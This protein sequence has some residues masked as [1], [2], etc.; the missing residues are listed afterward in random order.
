MCR[1]C[2][3][4]ELF[5]TY[6]FTVDQRYQD[7][8]QMQIMKTETEVDANDDKDTVSSLVLYSICVVIANQSSSSD[9]IRFIKVIEKRAYKKRFN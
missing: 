4:C 2:G 5:G 3:S 6:D 8:L 7:S 1:L 9:S